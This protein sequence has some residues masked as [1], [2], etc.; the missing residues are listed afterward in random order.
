MPNT[1]SGGPQWDREE[2]RQGF[3][4]PLGSSRLA[5]M[6]KKIRASRSDTNHLARFL[7]TVSRVRSPGGPPI[8]LGRDESVGPILERPSFL[9][10]ISIY[11]L[12][13]LCQAFRV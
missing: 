10:M 8:K 1:I 7:I 2:S 13:R 9:G 3:A 4:G 6:S 12:H 11:A 5:K